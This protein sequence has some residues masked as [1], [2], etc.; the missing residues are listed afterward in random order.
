MG[1]WENS[2]LFYS[3][4]CT[5]SITPILITFG[6]TGVSPVL[7]SVKMGWSNVN[8]TL[9]QFFF[10]NDYEY[11]D[12]DGDSV[13]AF[14]TWYLE[15]DDTLITTGQTKFR[16]LFS[17]SAGYIKGDSIYCKVYVRD[18]T[19]AISNTVRSE[20]VK[21]VNSYPEL[22]SFPSITPTPARAI[23]TLKC[24][25][26][27]ADIFDID[28]PNGPFQFLY[29]WYA[30]DVK[31]ENETS[32][33]YQPSA[34]EKGDSVYCTATPNDFNEFGTGSA[35]TSTTVT[36]VNSPPTVAYVRVEP[37]DLFTLT[38][39]VCAI[40]ELTDVDGDLNFDVTYN[41]YVN[42]E[43][44]SET[45]SLAH[46]DFKSGDIVRCEVFASD[47]F[48]TSASNPS[49]A[50]TVQNT[51]PV[52]TEL[53][54]EP[55]APL[56]SGNVTCSVVTVA[57]DDNDDPAKFVYVWQW[58]LNG[59]LVLEENAGLLQASYF[60]KEDV[61]SC[62]IKVTDE[63]SGYG[64]YSEKTEVTVVNS[65]PVLTGASLSLD[66]ISAP[67]NITCN[68]GVYF[69]FDNDAVELY[70]YQWFNRSELVAGATGKT[71]TAF[72]IKDVISCGVRAR[73]DTLYSSVQ[74]SE[75]LLIDAPVITS[76]VIS[77]PTNQDYVY[78][79]G[80]EIVITMNRETNFGITAESFNSSTSID[81]ATIDN[82]FSF[83]QSLGSDYVGKWLSAT[84]FHITVS[85][86]RE[87]G[88]L[89]GTATATILPSAL[90]YFKT[91]NSLAAGAL[92]T[93][94][95]MTGTT[96][97]AP[98][99][100]IVGASGRAGIST[101]ITQF[102]AL[103]AA[104]GGYDFHLMV[105]GGGVYGYG[106]N[107]NGQLGLTATQITQLEASSS[108][109][110]KQEV[111]TTVKAE[112]LDAVYCTGV[113]AGWYHS[114]ALCYAN[115]DDA[116]S[117]NDAIV[118]ATGLNAHGQLGVA[119]SDE[120]ERATFSEV[121]FA[122]ASSVY[123][124]AAGAGF[125]VLVSTEG[126]YAMGLGFGSTYVDGQEVS[127]PQLVTGLEGK[128]TDVFD[129]TSVKKVV[130]GSDH[131]LFLTNDETVYVWGSNAE[132]QLAA[133]K[134]VNVVPSPTM[135][136]YTITTDTDGTNN[137]L[138]NTAVDIAAG[139]YHSIAI[140]MEG[141][142]FC[143]GK[144]SDSQ[145]GL[146]PVGSSSASTSFIY[147]P[148]KLDSQ[149]YNYTYVQYVSAFSSYSLI[150]TFDGKVYAFG[151][152]D[153]GAMGSGVK[154][155]DYP[156]YISSNDVQIARIAAT[157]THSLLGTVTALSTCTESC[158]FHGACYEGQCY[159]GDTWS[160]DACGDAL[161]P[162]YNGKYCNGN[163]T[164]VVGGNLAT[165][166]CDISF[167]G[168]SC[169]VPDCSILSTGSCQNGGTCQ[170]GLTKDINAI[171]GSTYLPYCECPLG[172]AAPNCS[173]CEVGYTGE[174]CDV[175]DCARFSDCNSNGTCVA[176]GFTS[177]CDC[178]TGFSG[179]DCSITSC[180][181][182]STCSGH[183]TCDISDPTQPTCVCDVRW[184]GNICN[185]AQC[186]GYGS[187]GGSCN[188]HGTCNS[189]GDIP[190]CVCD[191]Y[192]T[193]D[194]CSV[195]NC[196]SLNDCSGQGKCFVGD[197]VTGTVEPYC[198]C[199]SGYTGTT[200]SEETDERETLFL[201][202]ISTIVGLVTVIVCILMYR[203]M[204]RQKVVGGMGM[205]SNFQQDSSFFD[206]TRRISSFN[207]F[208]S[209]YAQPNRR[210]RGGTPMN[211]QAMNDRRSFALRGNIIV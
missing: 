199:N 203:W 161:C 98:F 117:K 31:V 56:A 61:V 3:T 116:A 208:Q 118:Y 77:D 155:A 36:L 165:C 201:I 18:T 157:N 133:S 23:D 122:S 114:L 139:A 185:N 14:Y 210:G 169:G 188:G 29:E 73:D 47:G 170:L 67:S 159:C 207:N 134:S 62:Q 54:I 22:A 144:N 6:M 113:A 190:K 57:D 149:Y 164:C 74:T 160:G 189:E 93:S 19:G 130:C 132:G 182:A 41:F 105:A 66:D 107:S 27:E 136:S 109:E 112:S 158:N 102:D 5:L 103:E 11:T 43:K 71:F 83:S 197:Q 68:P 211:V 90:L 69:D 44:V 179:E 30:K 45:N 91:D 25:A 10:C 177:M 162:V 26:D 141:F 7:L 127:T 104:S 72:S 28:D 2:K 9:G 184:G 38:D 142:V 146:G 101:S 20:S 206:P 168:D 156:T 106:R 119:P 1:G 24:E 108:Y 70:E 64:N 125:S 32:I 52:V 153:H 58:H 163:G 191:M 12:G 131:V 121:S 115:K 50:V 94:P 120:S 34:Y 87:S 180:G 143:W 40:G 76:F 200:C 39:A 35:V 176:S 154:Y 48:D 96:G 209:T 82:M 51:P 13:T 53:K 138:N 152:N 175:L 192:Y 88:D 17:D 129:V 85:D 193:T 194:D 65:A 147:S 145:C 173:V 202:L 151:W 46:T 78:G 110:V 140:S 181:G 42:D 195:I 79:S 33:T 63:F 55:A 124:V 100:F 174:N 49:D 128:D 99:G 81:K 186:L 84:Q 16:Y 75:T 166:N 89:L 4:P 8:P 92:S 126:I 172:W 15:P 178:D 167:K 148:T 37:A 97:E 123:I 204:S 80:D 21:F 86:A 205:D 59:E 60:V 196:A 198:E 137:D 183:G 171:T 135:L 187:S 111:E 95:A 150:S